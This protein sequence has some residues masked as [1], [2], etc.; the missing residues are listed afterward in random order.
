MSSISVLDEKTGRQCYVDDPDDL[1]QGEEL[2]FILSLHGGGSVGAW[3][4]L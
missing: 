3:Q 2:T 1:E 4:R